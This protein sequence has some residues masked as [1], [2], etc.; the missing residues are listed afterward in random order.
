MAGF[1][2]VTDDRAKAEGLLD[3]EG[4]AMRGGYSTE[5]KLLQKG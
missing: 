2:T 3:R 1:K 4:V 5:I